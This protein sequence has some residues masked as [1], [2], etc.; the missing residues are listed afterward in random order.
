MSASPEQF[1]LF[2]TGRMSAGRLCEYEGLNLIDANDI[3][4][5]LQNAHDRIVNREA[6]R[7]LIGLINGIRDGKLTAAKAKELFDINPEA[8]QELRNIIFPGGQQRHRPEEPRR[9]P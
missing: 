9:G 4:M 7:M 5:G 6:D 1:E 8:L 3:L 2:L